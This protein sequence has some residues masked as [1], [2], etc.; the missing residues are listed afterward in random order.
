MDD[1]E[2]A[3]HVISLPLVPDAS[4]AAAAAIIRPPTTPHT[5]TPPLWHLFA[6]AHLHLLYEHAH[7]STSSMGRSSH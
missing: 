2:S 3:F 6:N 7:I 4:C 1:Q 5:H